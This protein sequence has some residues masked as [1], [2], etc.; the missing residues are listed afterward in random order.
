MHVHVVVVCMCKCA[1]A[2]NK[3]KYEESPTHWGFWH[4]LGLEMNFLG[5]RE[6]LS[7]SHFTGK[8]IENSHEHRLSYWGWNPELRIDPVF[9][10]P[11][12]TVCKRELEF[13]PA[14]G[15]TPGKGLHTPEAGSYSR[16]SNSTPL[17]TWLCFWLFSPITHC[18]Q[19]N[20]LNWRISMF[21][22]GF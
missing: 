5:V 7:Y 20:A 6:G 16:H 22:L 19:K 2:G 1:C 12:W 14:K 13:S 15:E 9:P 3:C 21:R 11:P 8:E 4:A 10:R 17:V 18:Q